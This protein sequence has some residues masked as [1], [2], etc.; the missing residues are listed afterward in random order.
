M[1]TFTPFASMTMIVENG[2]KQRDAFSGIV[3]AF[4]SVLRKTRMFG[5]CQTRRLLPHVS[6]LPCPEQDGI[7]NQKR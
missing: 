5:R 3:G 1:S 6:V 4:P 2:L 7:A